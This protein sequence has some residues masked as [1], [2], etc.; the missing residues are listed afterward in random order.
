MHEAAHPDG[1]AGLGL[2]QTLIDHILATHTDVAGLGPITAESGA[3]V[4]VATHLGPG[5]PAAVSDATWRRPLRDSAQ[6][7]GYS[8]A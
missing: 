3:R 4:L 7:S 1:L 6:Q 8:A 5:G 2:P